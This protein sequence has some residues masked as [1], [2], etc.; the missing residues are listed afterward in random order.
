MPEVSAFL[1]TWYLKDPS[2][3]RPRT[4]ASTSAPSTQVGTCRAGPMRSSATLTTAQAA[5]NAPPDS[6]TGPSV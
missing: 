6:M 3:K 5:T 1:W 2:R 4:V